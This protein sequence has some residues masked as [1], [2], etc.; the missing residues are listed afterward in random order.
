MSRP[1]PVDATAEGDTLSVLDRTDLATRQTPWHRSISAPPCP[2]ARPPHK[3]L[4]IIV[5]VVLTA[6]LGMY[7]LFSRL[8]KKIFDPDPAIVKDNETVSN[9]K[10]YSVRYPGDP[11]MN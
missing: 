9:D 4:P 8:L 6:F 2:R 7:L 1:P 3:F 5:A 10:E 11:M